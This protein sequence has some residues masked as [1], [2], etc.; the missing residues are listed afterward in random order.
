MLIERLVSRTVLRSP[1]A[2]VLSGG[3]KSSGA[4]VSGGVRGAKVFHAV[5]ALRVCSRL[6]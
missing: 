3:A 1:I 6:M 2:A 4:Q 5:A